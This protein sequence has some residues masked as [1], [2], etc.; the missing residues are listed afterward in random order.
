MINYLIT[1]FILHVCALFIYELLLKNTT[2]LNGNRSYLLLV[3]VVLWLIPFINIAALN[4]EP[5][6][7]EMVFQTSFVQKEVT[8]SQVVVET[9]TIPI[10]M[11][12]R[13]ETSINFS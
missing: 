13:E 3:P 11:E 2:F 1:V 5:V 12:T 10:Q 8:E 7:E 6:V 9:P 4:P